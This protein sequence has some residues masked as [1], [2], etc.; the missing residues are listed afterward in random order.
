MYHYKPKLV[1]IL[2]ET[3]KYIEYEIGSYTT[4]QQKGLCVGGVLDGQMLTEQQ[5]FELGHSKMYHQYNSSW[6]MRKHK[7]IFAYIEDNEKPRP[8]YRKKR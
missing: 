3:D 7:F 4:K 1:K 8:T 2:K 6:S 5:I